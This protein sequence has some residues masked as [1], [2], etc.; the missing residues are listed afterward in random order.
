MQTQKKEK[1]RYRA[2]AYRLIKENDARS[3]EGAAMV[4]QHYV[5]P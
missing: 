5:T 2:C 1:P 4:M 3:R